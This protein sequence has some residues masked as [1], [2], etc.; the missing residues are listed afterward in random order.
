MDW[1]T[2]FGAFF[3]AVVVWAVIKALTD[4][5]EDSKDHLMKSIIEYEDYRAT[6]KRC[7]ERRAAI[8]KGKLNL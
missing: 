6:T 5:D 8:R 4:M 3:I 7:S 2:V 1:N